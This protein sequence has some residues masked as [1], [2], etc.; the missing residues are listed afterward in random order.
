MVS[1]ILGA[2][3][4]GY[5]IRLEHRHGYQKLQRNLLEN[6]RDDTRHHLVGRL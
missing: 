4:L 5:R 3:N 6:H 2:R 1:R